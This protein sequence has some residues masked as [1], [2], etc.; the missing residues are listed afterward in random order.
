MAAPANIE[1]CGVAAADVPCLEST[2]K[3]NN[4]FHFVVVMTTDD[5]DLLTPIKSLTSTTG[6]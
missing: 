2:Y 3:A 6:G 1:L 4:E 5:P